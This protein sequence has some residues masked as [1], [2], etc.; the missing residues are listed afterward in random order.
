M[1]L[2]IALL[3]HAE[4]RVAAALLCTALL[5]QPVWFRK[6]CFFWEMALYPEVLALI[7]ATG[8]LSRHHRVQGE[9]EIRTAGGGYRSLQRHSKEQGHPLPPL[10]AFDN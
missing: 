4:V 1:Q 6:G 2:L 9:R 7:V 8:L 10:L 3:S 5:N